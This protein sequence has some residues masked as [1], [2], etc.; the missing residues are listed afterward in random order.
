MWSQRAQ[1]SPTR[2]DE[3]EAEFG[4][5][6][7]FVAENAWEEIEIWVLAGL[8]LPQDCTWAEVR[9]EVH[10]EDTFLVRLVHERGV[11]DGRGGG[12][13]AL[14]EEAAGSTP[15][16]RRKCPEDFDALARRLEGAV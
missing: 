2:L 10:R 9:G 12:R 4:D 16:I 13:K 5:G 1:E 8:A 7:T 11:A 14:G 15:S 6:R 3:I